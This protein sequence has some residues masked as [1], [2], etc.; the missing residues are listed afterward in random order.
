MIKKKKLQP[1]KLTGGNFFGYIL[2]DGK[3]IR[4]RVPATGGRN[5]CRNKLRDQNLNNKMK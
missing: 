4:V 3:S 1:R 5:G 2:P